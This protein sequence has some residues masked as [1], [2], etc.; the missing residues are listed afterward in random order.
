[1][2]GKLLTKGIGLLLVLMLCC[3]GLTTAW[4]D[5]PAAA[6]NSGDAAQNV[7]TGGIDVSILF[8]KTSYKIGSTLVATYNIKGGSGTY[9]ELHCWCYSV[10]NGQQ[11]LSKYLRLKNKSG[12]IKFKPKN[13]QE[14]YIEI[15]ALDSKGKYVDVLS[16]RVALTGAKETEPIQVTFSFGKDSY[17]YGETV[18]AKYQITG[19][20]GQYP[21]IQYYVYGGG[22]GSSVYTKQGTL[23][24]AS[25]T[26]SWPNGGKKH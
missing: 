22:T 12:T 11:V 24:K 17:A 21:F 10:D 4:A 15:Y 2:K 25:G 8:S 1:M 26:R 3:T 19:G 9:T 13:G 20:S 7:A 16:D 23:K 5:T 14:A 6:A 18:E